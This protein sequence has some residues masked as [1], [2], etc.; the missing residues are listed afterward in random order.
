MRPRLVK[1]CYTSKQ[2]LPVEK[3]NNAYK[4]L[5]QNLHD[6]GDIHES[7][8]HFNTEMDRIADLPDMHDVD[9]KTP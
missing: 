2:Q 4:L 8:D 7:N 5:H 1:N 6:E 9:R 3:F